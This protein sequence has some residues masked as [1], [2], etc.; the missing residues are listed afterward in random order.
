[1]WFLVCNFYRSRSLLYVSIQTTKWRNRWHCVVPFRV[2]AVGSRKLQQRHNIL[3]WFCRLL[4]VCFYIGICW[5]YHTRPRTFKNGPLCFIPFNRFIQSSCTT[6]IHHSLCFTLYM[7]LWM[8][9]CCFIYVRWRPRLAQL[10][11]H[12]SYGTSTSV[13]TWMGGRQGKLGAVNLWTWNLTDRL[14][15]CYCADTDTKWIE[16]TVFNETF[17]AN[18]GSAPR[19]D[20]FF[21]PTLWLISRWGSLLYELLCLIVDR[22][23]F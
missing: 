14:Y 9:L 21:P 16:L 20:C 6:V 12:W 23:M 11:V 18:S 10:H 1:M 22:T 4:A 13:S 8:N 19:C 2:M 17:A 7:P 5:Y 15:R 3:T